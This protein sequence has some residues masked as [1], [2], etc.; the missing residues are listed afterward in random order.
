MFKDKKNNTSFMESGK[1]QNRISHGTTI[2]GDVESDG[3]F[4]IDGTINGTLK[5]P[6]KVVIGKEGKVDGTLECN[7]ADI[8]GSFSG[9][10]IVQGLLSLKSTATIEG[11][12]FTEKLAVEPGA[13]FNATCK[14]E[15]GIKS[16]S[17]SKKDISA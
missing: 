5:T 4:R 11:D 17:T 13:I 12:V 8:E 1:S 14:M 7:N 3:G 15:S 9:K 2:N 6:G 10:L 16:I